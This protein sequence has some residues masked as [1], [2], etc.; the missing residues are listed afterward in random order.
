[1]LFLLLQPIISSPLHLKITNQRASSKFLFIDNFHLP[2]FCQQPSSPNFSPR[3]SPVKLLIQ[4]QVAAAP[5]SNTRAAPAPSFGPIPQRSAWVRRYIHPLRDIV[6]DE[7]RRYLYKLHSSLEYHTR[8]SSASGGGHLELSH[9]T[10]AEILRSDE[11]KASGQVISLNMG[12]H[13]VTFL[14]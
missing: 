9:A 7:V 5:H 12:R 2:H 10:L 6:L 3:R 4:T 13:M 11:W 14:A 8:V 1:M